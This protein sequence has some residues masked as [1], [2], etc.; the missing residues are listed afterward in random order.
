[1]TA[2]RKR[3]YRYFDHDHYDCAEHFYSDYSNEE[4]LVVHISRNRIV[5]MIKSGISKST[6]V[7]S[8]KEVCLQTQ[9][10]KFQPDPRLSLRQN[11]DLM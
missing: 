5:V 7:P 11:K 2:Y 10:A 4:Y 9:K 6:A 1:M 3:T 8:M